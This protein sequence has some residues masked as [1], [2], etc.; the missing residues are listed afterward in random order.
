[1][2]GPKPIDRTQLLAWIEEHAQEGSG[3]RRAVYT[4]LATRI[5]RG[6]FNVPDH[7]EKQA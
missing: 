6:Q 4:G 3:V 7:E 1:M 2:T 5:R